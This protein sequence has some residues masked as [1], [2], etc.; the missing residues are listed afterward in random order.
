MAHTYS[1]DHLVTSTEAV[2]IEVADKA[3]MVLRG[4][5]RLPNGRDGWEAIYGLGSGD[6]QYPATVTYRVENQT[7]QGNPVRRLSM[8]FNTWAA[9]DDG[10][11]VVIRKPISAEISIVVP[12]DL[13]IELADLDDLFGNSVSFLYSSVSSGTRTTTYLQK[14]LYGGPQVA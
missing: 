6:S 11:S 12:A 14:L 3:G 7:R 8:I 10:V 2:N 4:T 9:D 5:S 1:I 13:T